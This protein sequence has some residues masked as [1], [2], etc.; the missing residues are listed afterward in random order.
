VYT[1]G[2]LLPE[3]EVPVEIKR[4]QPCM[5]HYTPPPQVTEIPS[6]GTAEQ[7]DAPAADAAKSAPNTPDH[8][9]EPVTQA[10][11]ATAAAP[12]EADFAAETKKRKRIQPMVI[13]ALGNETAVPCSTSSSSSSSAVA[14]AAV[15]SAV[16]AP[17]ASDTALPAETDAA[18]AALPKAAKKRIA[19]QLVQP[20]GQ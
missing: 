6:T 1:T 17:T 16:D 20:E 5:F 4:A 2:E 13:A 18:S 3:D 12:V 10:V 7:A 9:T 14:V 19:P 15:A 11:V 8:A